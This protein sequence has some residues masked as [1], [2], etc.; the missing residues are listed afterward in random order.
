MRFA[1]VLIQLCCAAAAWM[2]GQSVCVAYSVW[3]HCSREGLFQD[4]GRQDAGVLQAQEELVRHKQL[5]SYL[6]EQCA[7]SQ[8]DNMELR[9]R[10]CLLERLPALG[11]A[12]P[13]ACMVDFVGRKETY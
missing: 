3:Q 12:S 9:Q 8:L 7:R 5:I 2:P 11:Y 13:S 1:S 10:V 4:R 6:R